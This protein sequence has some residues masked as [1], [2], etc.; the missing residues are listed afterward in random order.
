[1]TIHQVVEE[2]ML[3]ELE[4]VLLQLELVLQLQH[5]MELLEELELV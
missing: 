3:E 4:V 5:P 1:M 2:I